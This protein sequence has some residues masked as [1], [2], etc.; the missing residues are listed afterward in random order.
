MRVQFFL[1]P[2]ELSDAVICLKLL[3]G[4]PHGKPR[5]K[6][7]GLT[8][9]GGAVINGVSSLKPHVHGAVGLGPDPES[10]TSRMRGLCP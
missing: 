1:R 6:R 3:E 7:N 9:H 2:T 10:W 8:D 5:D 4:S